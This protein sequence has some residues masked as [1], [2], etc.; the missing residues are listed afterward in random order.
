MFYIFVSLCLQIMYDKNNA[1]QHLRKHVGASLAWWHSYKWATFRI[2][3]VFGSDFIGPLFHH[4]FPE[5]SYNVKLMSFPAATAMLSYMR[6]AYPAIRDELTAALALGNVVSKSCL[7]LLQNLQ[8]LL[9]YF[10]PTVHFL[11][12][13]HILDLICYQHA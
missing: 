5:R 2:C 6:L 4:L 7:V 9:E 11:W 1:G 10:I 13:F 3:V 8:D 12:H